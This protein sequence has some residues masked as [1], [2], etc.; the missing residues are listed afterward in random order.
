MILILI[1]NQKMT[2]IQT[3]N[4]INEILFITMPAF[5]KKNISTIES[6]G[7]KLKQHRQ[8]R[9]LSIEKAARLMKINTSFLKNLEHDCYDR[10]PADVYTQKFLQHYANFLFLNPETVINTFKKEKQI[11]FKLKNSQATKLPTKDLISKKISNFLLNPK[12]IKYAVFLIIIAIVLIYIGISVNKIFSPPELIIKEPFKPSIITN[13]SSIL[14]SG[15]TEPEVELK[16]NDRQILIDNSGKFEISMDLQK[17]L[18]IIKIS[19]KKKHSRPQIV[20]RQ[21]IVEDN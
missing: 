9:G 5:N 19:A 20:Y 7:E 1:L 15:I 18:N 3:L 2:M 4:K 10:L 12:T 8:Q 13:E 21:V 14:L 11:Y 6:L 17:G 16:I